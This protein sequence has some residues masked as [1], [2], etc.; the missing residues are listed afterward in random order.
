MPACC[1]R[2]WQALTSATPPRSCPLPIASLRPGLESYYLTNTLGVPQETT[3]AG[4]SLILSGAFDRFPRLRVLLAH[5]GGFLP[6]QLGRL[7]HAA[8]V[9]PEGRGAATRLPSEYLGN[10]WFD[11]ITHAAAPLEFLGRLAPGRVVVGSDSPFDMGDPDPVAHARAAGLDSDA[12]D[13]AT[14]SLLGG[15]GREPIEAPAASGEVAK[16]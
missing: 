5:G 7:D 14:A 3:A 8:R 16:Q 9:R 11:T 1:S 6:Y 2:L 12:L 15:S 13:S 10:L 4:A